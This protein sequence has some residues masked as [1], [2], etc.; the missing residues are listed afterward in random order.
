[1]Q[2][3]FNQI[4]SLSKG[5]NVL[6]EEILNREKFDVRTKAQILRLAL[7]ATLGNKVK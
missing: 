7:S 1:M 6:H 4:V 5:Q 2:K 3:A